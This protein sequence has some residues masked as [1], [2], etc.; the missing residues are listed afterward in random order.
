VNQS[1]VSEHWCNPRFTK[2]ERLFSGC[3]RAALP[4]DRSRRRDVGGTLNL[5]LRL[6]RLSSQ[7][8]PRLLACHRSAAIKCSDPSTGGIVLLLVGAAV[9]IYLL[10]RFHP[11]NRMSRKLQAEDYSA[12]ITIGE[13]ALRKSE[14]AG[15]RFNLALAYLG[16]GRSD[17]ARAIY[18]DLAAAQ[19]VPAPFTEDTYREALAT[20]DA[21]LHGR[22][23]PRS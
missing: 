6:G 4:P 14:D 15:I 19:E 8:H 2:Q 5:G 1:S 11:L 7:P 12:A 22:E 23:I 17:R 9:G 10:L 13:R 21:R 3:D 18:Q 20:L 16:D